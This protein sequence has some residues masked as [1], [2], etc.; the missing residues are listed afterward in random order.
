MLPVTSRVLC[1][2]LDFGATN[3]LTKDDTDEQFV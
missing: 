3:E 1:L 2:P